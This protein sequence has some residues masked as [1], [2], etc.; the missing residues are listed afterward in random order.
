VENLPFRR[1]LE[2]FEYWRE[3]PPSHIL[4]R[5]HYG[6]KNEDASAPEIEEGQ[7]PTDMDISIAN[8]MVRSGAAMPMYREPHHRQAAIRRALEEARN[9]G[10]K[11]G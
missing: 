9:R 8:G 4:H 2:L 6:Y 3:S 7:M 5:M 1:A 10:K 11:N